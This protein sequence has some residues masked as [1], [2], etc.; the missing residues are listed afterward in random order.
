MWGKDSSGKYQAT[1]QFSFDQYNQNQVLYL[2]YSNN[3]GNQNTGL[4][5]DDWETSPTFQVWQAEYKKAQHL[6]DGSVKEA[7]LKKLM[8]PAI[9]LKAITQQVFVGKEE[10][11]TAMVTLAYRLG[12]SLL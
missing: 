6:A 1:G 10:N 2:T 4:H 8:E 5:N 11:K 12:S 7:L 9:G 3:N